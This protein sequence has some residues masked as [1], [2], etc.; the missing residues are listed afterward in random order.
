MKKYLM[1]ITF[2][3]IICLVIVLILQNKKSEKVEREYYNGLPVTISQVLFLHN[4]SIP[5]RT[6]GVSDYVFVAK[7]NKILRTEYKN[8]TEVQVNLFKKKTITTPYTVYSIDVIENIKGN[9]IT[10]ESIEYMQ[11]GGLDEDKK[12]YT[13]MRDTSLLNEGE[14][15]ILL[16]ETF[17]GHG[18][19]IEVTDSNRRIPLGSDYNLESKTIYDTINRYKQAYQ[20]EIIPIYENGQQHERTIS[21]YD[22]NY[23]E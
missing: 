16:A 21:K 6:V 5:E 11:Y 2:A 22:I 18:G 19:I 1:E 20:N 7:I 10:T 8:P 9:L 13:F 12:G 4:T 23:K 15:Y 17:G 14:Y 3:I